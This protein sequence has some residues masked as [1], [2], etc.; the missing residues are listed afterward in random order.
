MSEIHKLN[1]KL[2]FIELDKR[3][4]Y[5]MNMARTQTKVALLIEFKIMSIGNHFSNNYLEVR[6]K[7]FNPAISQK[8]DRDSIEIFFVKTINLVR[9]RWCI[10]DRRLKI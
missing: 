1:I 3:R 4:K 10:F 7:R 6:E 9:W 2:N 5:L 8:C